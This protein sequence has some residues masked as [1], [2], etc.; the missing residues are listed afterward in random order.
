MRH[1][2]WRCLRAGADPTWAELRH[3]TSISPTPEIPFGGAFAVTVAE[4][5]LVRA[6]YDNTV[7]R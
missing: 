4:Q 5:V 1:R 7:R 3:G 2:D 6:T